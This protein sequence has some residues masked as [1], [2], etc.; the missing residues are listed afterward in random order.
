MSRRVTLKSGIDFTNSDES[1]D[2]SVGNSE[3]FGRFSLFTSHID[4]E[5]MG[6]YMWDDE[7]TSTP[8]PF[9]ID[10]VI[11]I[12]VG[13]SFEDYNLNRVWRDVR[14]D[15]GTLERWSF[16]TRPGCSSEEINL[17]L[18]GGIARLSKQAET[19]KAEFQIA[20]AGPLASAVIGAGL[21]GLARFLRDEDDYGLAGT[22][23]CPYRM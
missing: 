13:Y 1:I 23:P 20:L 9:A 17:W 10:S 6:G 7:P 11:F 15:L 3:F 8:A 14:S 19:A 2:N 21:I 4:I 5:L 16:A 12:F 22:V 18:L